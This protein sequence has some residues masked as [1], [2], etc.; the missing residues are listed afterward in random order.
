LRL[1]K[2]ELLKG[3]EECVVILGEPNLFYFSG[4]RGVGALVYTDGN[5]YL[6]VPILERNRSMTIKG[7]QVK[8]YSTYRVD[9]EAY[10]GT[11]DDL[12]FR[13]CGERRLAVD[14]NWV[15]TSTYIRISSKFKLRDASQEILGMRAVKEEEEIE[16]IKRSWKSTAKAV[17]SLR[18]NL[19]EGITETELAGLLDWGMRKA[20]AEDYAFPTIVA[21]SEN[22]AFPHHVP[23]GRKLRPGDNVVVDLGAKVD[24]YCFDS[25]RSFLTERAGEVLKVFEVVLQAQA[26][27]IDVVRP[28]VTGSEVDMAARRVIERSG[29]G[30]HFIH[31]TGHGVGVEVHESPAISPTS[32]DELKENMVITVE[33]GIYIP[34]K[35]GI[36]VEDT[37]IVKRKAEVLDTPFKFAF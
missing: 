32:K 13:I 1:H 10:V 22:S 14:L 17:E 21:F 28:G 35:F 4:Y 5:P 12:I 9:E 33:P 15:N 30:K 7:L 34:G 16:R 3:E 29:Y 27:A 24:G 31:S 36:R 26:E 6:L 8:A 20:G 25:T 19:V 37:L 23:T 18:E 11:L 2:L